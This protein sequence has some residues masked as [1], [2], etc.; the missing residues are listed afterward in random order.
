MCLSISV[1]FTIILSFECVLASGND[2]DL[3]YR[4]SQRQLN[5]LAPMMYDNPREYFVNGF[6]DVCQDNIQTIVTS[7]FFREPEKNI[8]VALLDRTSVKVTI[9]YKRDLNISAT[10]ALFRRSDTVKDNRSVECQIKN[11]V[12]SV[13][14]NVGVYKTLRFRQE[15]LDGTVT[16]S[17]FLK[18][19]LSETCVMT[20][21]SKVVFHI[22]RHKIDSIFQITYEYPDTQT[23]FG[24]LKDFDIH[25][26]L[27]TTAQQVESLEFWDIKSF[28][29]WQDN[30]IPRLPPSIPFPVNL[31][32]VDDAERFEVWIS[33]K[34]IH[35][36]W[37]D[38]PQFYMSYLGNQFQ[39]VLNEY[40][41]KNKEHKQFMAE[42]IFFLP[43]IAKVF[44]NSAINVVPTKLNMWTTINKNSMS[45]YL[46]LSLDLTATLA[47]KD[48]N[49]TL[50]ILSIDMNLQFP[51]QLGVNNFK[52]NAKLLNLGG[53]ITIRN[54]AIGVIKNDLLFN[55]L[56]VA[57]LVYGEK[58]MNK[59]FD[60]PNNRSGIELYKVVR[61]EFDFKNLSI[62]L[63][64]GYAVLEAD[65][66]PSQF[67]NE[68]NGEYTWVGHYSKEDWT[69]VLY[70]TT[71]VQHSTPS[72][73]RHSSG[74]EVGR[75]FSLHWILFGIFLAL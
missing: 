34:G 69:I 60:D 4:I 52:L 17:E 55:L 37:G 18:T 2:G 8:S 28:V 15:T 5:E 9:T 12:F 65:V 25:A 44:P 30:T 11:A 10:Y 46:N 62:R 39:K 16:G 1:L 19:F 50:N 40:A 64:E 14:A 32:Q 35:K 33:E 53:T 58:M 13:I 73:I 26:S 24:F 63:E 31:P 45:L 71:P 56:H 61:D 42:D 7:P 57:P 21:L 59:L 38:I 54:S 72:T 41:E 49:T 75:A 48:K 70:D 27:Y 43:M 51:V 3:M 47:S 20:L 66:V 29:L 74:G 23:D 68:T 67:H 22:V 36:L 6:V